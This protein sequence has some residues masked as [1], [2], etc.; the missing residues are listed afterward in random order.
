M[1]RVLFAIQTINEQKAKH[2]RAPDEPPPAWPS[3]DLNVR[4]LSRLRRCVP[5]G[6]V[7]VNAGW[8]GEGAAQTACESIP[9]RGRNDDA[10]A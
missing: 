9:T 6:I 10:E 7:R 4:Q 5:G 1:F 2:K 3:A 8:E